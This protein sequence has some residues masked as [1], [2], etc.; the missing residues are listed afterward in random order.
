[1]VENNFKLT[2][3]KKISLVSKAILAM[4]YKFLKL[5]SNLETSSKLLLYEIYTTVNHS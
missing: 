2:V 1:M 4:S 5:L 3:Y